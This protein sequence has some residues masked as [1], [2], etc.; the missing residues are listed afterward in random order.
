[1]RNNP[2]PKDDTGRHAIWDMRVDRDIKA[3]V[4]A[5]WNAVANDFNDP[6]PVRIAVQAG[7]LLTLQVEIEMWAVQP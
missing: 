7:L 6:Q 1:M 2:F 4:A 5:D 3:F